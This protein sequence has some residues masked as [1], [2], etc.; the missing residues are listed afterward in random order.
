L[1]KIFLTGATGFIGS[2]VVEKLQQMD[3]NITCLVRKSSNLRWL[4]NMSVNLVSGSLFDPDSFKDILIDTD[5]IFHIAGLTKALNKKEYFQGNVETTKILL[6]TVDSMNHSLKRFL[7]VSSQAAVGPSPTALPIEENSPCQP[8][9][10]YGESK[11][12]GEKTAKEFMQRIPLT[13]VRPPSVFG[14]RD[15]DVYSFFKSI[16]KRIN[17]RI[18][19]VDQLISLV[20]VEDLANGII[21]AAFSKKSIGETYF[22]CEETPYYWSQV[23]KISSEILGKRFFTVKIPFALALL[24]GSIIEIYSRIRKK[25]LIINRQ[26]LKEISQPYWTL[27]VNKAKKD[28]GYVTNFPVA[29]GIGKTIEWYKKENWL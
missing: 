6:Q 15:R 17:F 3:H 9:T 21:L 13:I 12:Q 7:L 23:A 2:F 25:P 20:Y 27:S 24:T 29:A 28:L 16:N 26:K 4:Q 19:N 10:D 8:L 11:L 14:P 1:S 5:Y 22:L 18:G